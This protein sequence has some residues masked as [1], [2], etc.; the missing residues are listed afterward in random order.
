M[1]DMGTG[2]E[3]QQLLDSLEHFGLSSPLVVARDPNDRG[4]YH[5]VDGGRRYLALLRLGK[6]AA[7][8]WINE[9]ISTRKMEALRYQLNE[10]VNPWTKAEEV[11]VQRRLAG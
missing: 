5:I 11:K 10:L 2:V 1:R 8:C 7:Y 3:R 4:L 6:K 9:P